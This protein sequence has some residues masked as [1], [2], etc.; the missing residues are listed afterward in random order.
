MRTVFYSIL[1]ISFISC[2]RSNRDA[3]IEF[4][5]GHFIFRPKNTRLE[6]E[7]DRN[8]SFQIETIKETGKRSKWKIDWG[9][10]CEYKLTYVDQEKN[11]GDTTHLTFK[12][13][14]FR[15]VHTA[16]KYYVF[17]WKN[18]ETKQV[19]VDTIWKL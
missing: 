10:D 19:F 15:I 1:I 7:F 17:S 4:R 6:Y 13:L 12:T 8:D 3:C 18:P 11:K 16:D 9:S 14:Y 5:K 2:S